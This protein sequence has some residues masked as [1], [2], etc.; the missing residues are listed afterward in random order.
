MEEANDV[1]RVGPRASAVFSLSAPGVGRAPPL[2]HDFAQKQPQ[3]GRGVTVPSRTVTCTYITSGMQT[4]DLDA[5]AG[6]V[7]E[8]ALVYH[9]TCRHPLFDSSAWTLALVP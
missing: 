8:V 9:S 6:A 5:N 2:S 4:S 7:S 3:L 1:V